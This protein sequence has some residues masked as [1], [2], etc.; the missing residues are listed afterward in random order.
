VTSSGFSL[1]FLPSSKT[2]IYPKVLFINL[3][4]EAFFSKLG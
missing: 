2:G 4:E 3:E 1:E